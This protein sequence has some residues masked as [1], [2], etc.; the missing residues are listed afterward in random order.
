MPGVVVRDGIDQR[1]GERVDGGVRDVGQ[2]PVVVEQ[3]EP[4]QALHGRGGIADASGVGSGL[5]RGQ[6]QRQAAG[7]QAAGLQR[8]QLLAAQ[9]VAVGV[10]G[11]PP[12]EGEHGV[13]LVGSVAGCQFV[14]DRRRR[15]AALLVVLDDG[16]R[17][18]GGLRL[19]GEHRL[20]EQR[21]QSGVAVGQLA[22]A[23][24]QGGVETRD[25]PRR[26]VAQQ[27]TLLLAAVAL[28]HG[29]QRHEDQVGSEIALTRV[30]QAEGVAAGQQQ[31]AALLPTEGPEHRGEHRPPLGLDPDARLVGPRFLE[32]ALEVIDDQQHRLRGQWAGDEI[33]ERVGQFS[34]VGRD[35]AAPAVPEWRPLGGRAGVQQAVPDFQRVVAAEHHHT[36]ELRQAVVGDARGQARLAEVSHA[37]HQHRPA[38][39]EGAEHLLDRAPPADEVA[40]RRHRHRGA[41]LVEKM[42]FAN[43]AAQR[44]PL[45]ALGEQRL[46]ATRPEVDPCHVPVLAAAWFLCMFAVQP[47]PCP[48]RGRHDIVPRGQRLVEPG[49][50]LRR[51]A[52]GHR[53]VPAEHLIDAAADQVGHQRAASPFAVAGLRRRATGGENDQPQVRAGGQGLG[54][55][56]RGHRLPLAAFVFEVH[57]GQPIVHAAVAAEVD[58]VR[59]DAFA[60]AQALLQT[61]E[62]AAFLDG[63]QQ[64][65]QAPGGIE[66]AG[67]LGLEVEHRFTLRLGRHEQQAEIAV[68]GLLRVLR[69]TEA[70][71]H[72]ERPQRVARQVAGPGV[73]PGQQFPRGV[74]QQAPEVVLD[75]GRLHDQPARSGTA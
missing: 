60:G 71:C 3:A 46:P 45:P 49:G 67:F 75:R 24:Q 15:H 63:Q 12:E 48:G 2:L 65:M 30:G 21:L 29:A 8:A 43:G 72:L 9:R 62:R 13:S 32:H 41:C 18:P 56:C 31:L 73:R 58:D 54:E 23:L 70:A 16:K 39:L 69:G 35:P 66:D 7:E 47:Q 17:L 61:G 52:V 59:R 34:L 6:R 5:Q 40:A 74:V 33:V 51:V 28:V 37:V 27:R 68:H 14:L 1:A 36:G 4:E 42:L 25:L 10:E 57:H 26:Q 20:A 19:A 22:G 53:S 50:E 55:F 38:V 11:H 64:L 44:P